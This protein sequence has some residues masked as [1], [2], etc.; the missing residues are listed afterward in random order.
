MILDGTIKSLQAT[1]KTLE[2][3]GD[4]SGLKM[5]SEQGRK[6]FRLYGTHRKAIRDTSSA[7]KW[8]PIPLLMYPIAA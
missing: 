2:I 7:L 1:L 8:S 4:M 6:W 5:N 3:V